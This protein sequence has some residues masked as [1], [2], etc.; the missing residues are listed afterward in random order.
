MNDE[1]AWHNEEF[2]NHGEG[3][4]QAWKELNGK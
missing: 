2:Y 1:R 4:E 3:F